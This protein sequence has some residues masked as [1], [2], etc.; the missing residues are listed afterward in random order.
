MKCAAMNEFQQPHSIA[1]FSQNIF[2]FR[3]G[4]KFKIFYFWSKDFIS[5]RS[6]ENKRNDEMDEMYTWL[7]SVMF[8]FS[9][10][11]IFQLKWKKMEEK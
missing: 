2:Y 11:K 4:W 10:A 5:V 6:E 3:N 8:D 1:G 7:V 9:A